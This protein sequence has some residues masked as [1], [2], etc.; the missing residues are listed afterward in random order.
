MSARLALPAV[1][2]LPHQPE[3]H[4]SHTACCCT[5]QVPRP[6]SL[7][8]PSFLGSRASLAAAMKEGS[9]VRRGRA[10]SLP[11]ITL[12]CPC[13]YATWRPGK[14]Q[15]IDSHVLRRSCYAWWTWA[16]KYHFN[17]A[18]AV[19]LRALHPVTNIHSLTHPPTHPQVPRAT[20][21][22]TPLRIS[23]PACATCGA[24]RTPSQQPP[25][26]HQ[27]A[28]PAL[29]PAQP[30]L[31]PLLPSTRLLGVLQRLSLPALRPPLRRALLPLLL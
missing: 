7:S 4:C 30:S 8:F 6:S 12:L 5:S 15:L 27:P 14:G 11:C 21:A 26:S 3:P 24:S 1:A 17:P 10:D 20:T 16:C 22:T 31:P 18:V 28:P 9:L 2:V 25:P 23:A 29:A 19:V 13:V